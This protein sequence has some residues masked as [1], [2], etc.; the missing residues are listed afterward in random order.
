MSKGFNM[1]GWR[2][3]FVCRPSEDRAGLRRREGQQRFGP[4]HG[5]PAGRRARPSSTPNWPTRIREKYRRRLQKLVAALKQG[6]LPGRRCRAA[7][8]SSTSQA[9][10][11][12]AE[13]EL[14]QRGGSVAVPDHGAIGLLRAVGRRGAVPAVLG[15][16]PRPRRR[17]RGRADGRDRRTAREAGIAVLINV[18]LLSG[19]AEKRTTEHYAPLPV[20]RALPERGWGW[21][22]RYSPR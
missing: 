20:L 22:Q 9:P 21:G 1:I 18:P 8:I 19:P 16:L 14:R 4:V 17:G 11:A 5:D 12:C 15:D 10:K 13:P 3:A 2:M 7:P 6:R